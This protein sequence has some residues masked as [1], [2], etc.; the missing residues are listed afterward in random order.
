MRLLALVLTILSLASA[1]TPDGAAVMSAACT[2]CHN[3][4]IIANA[5]RSRAS[6]S[7][8]VGDMIQRGAPVYP[9]EMK[10]LI[11]YL[12]QTV[13]PQAASPNPAKEEQKKTEKP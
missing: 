13:G 8:T 1:Q 10:I 4:R 5:H 6:W 2:G 3:L 11:D 9:E 7:A 12:A